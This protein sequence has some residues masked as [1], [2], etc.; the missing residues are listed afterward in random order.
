MS[1]LKDVAKLASVLHGLTV[2]ALV[3]LPIAIV[4]TIAVTPLV[5]DSLNTT[6]QVSPDITRTQMILF[7][8]VN[9]IS[10]L[11]LIWTLNEM[12]KLFGAYA[13]GE[14]LTD[15]CAGLILRIGKGLLALA[16]A[17]FVIR[18][19]ETVL[20]TLANQ[21]GDRSLSIGLASE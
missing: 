21:P 5:P 13:K 16:V 1:K 14:I 9:L 20:V 15:R 18:P 2:A 17:S 12:R 6:L 3:L 8:I 7:L 11:I 4:G 10:P 19:I